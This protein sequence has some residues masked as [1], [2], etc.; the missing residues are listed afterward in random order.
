MQGQI[1]F[2]CRLQLTSAVAVDELLLAQGNGLPGVHG[3][4]ALRDAGGGEGPAAPAGRPIHMLVL[5]RPHDA[6]RAPVNRPGKGDVL[7][8][9]GLLPVLAHPGNRQA[10]PQCTV[11]KPSSCKGDGSRGCTPDDGPQLSSQCSLPPIDCLNWGAVLMPHRP[12]AQHEQCNRISSAVWGD[13]E[14]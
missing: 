11:A 4:N 2:T 3:H 1:A 14:K 5:D 12:H 6:L 13:C 7:V 8:P 9:E 10:L